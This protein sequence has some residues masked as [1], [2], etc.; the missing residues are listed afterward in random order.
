MSDWVNCNGTWTNLERLR[1]IYPAPLSKTYHSNWY[2][3]AYTD[4][5]SVIEFLT[6]EFSSEQDAQNY[7]NNFMQGQNAINQIKIKES[8]IKEH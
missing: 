8:H 1:Y 5:D 3:A 4:D 6:D 7:L 2:I